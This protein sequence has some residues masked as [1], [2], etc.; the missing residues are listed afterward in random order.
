MIKDALP[1]DTP[2]F[3]GY[4]VTDEATEDFELDGLAIGDEGVRLRESLKDGSFPKRQAAIL[5]R[6]ANPPAAEAV[7]LRR[8]GG[9]GPIPHH[10]AVYPRIAA[11]G[12]ASM[13]V[14]DEPLRPVAPR[15]AGLRR[16]DAL[17][18]QRRQAR[19]RVQRIVFVATTMLELRETGQ[20][21]ADRLRGGGVRVSQPN[22]TLK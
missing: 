17:Q 19:R 13:A 3:D 10:A 5:L 21:I 9:R 11:S 12:V 18:V 20:D 15:A 16:L 14:G 8:Q 6:V 22:W 1:D 2:E 4:G 7:E